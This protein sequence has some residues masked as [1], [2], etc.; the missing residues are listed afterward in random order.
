M[1]AAPRVPP[2]AVART[3]A[4]LLLL[5]GVAC[6]G[7]PERAAVDPH[8]AL[9]QR[10]GIDADVRIHRITLGG[11]G[12]REHVVPPRLEVTSGDVVEFLTVDGRIH[13]VE[14]PVDSLSMVTAA[15]LRGTGQ[16]ESP[17]LVD[18]GTRFVITLRGAPPG[19]YL[20]R[21]RGSGQDAWGEIVVRSR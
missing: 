8:A 3:F 13:T 19:R 20:F 6:G 16:L 18:R 1:A 2:G 21:S 17:P 11:R 12:A 5:L 14:F 10:L 4:P 7:E 9:R 15:F